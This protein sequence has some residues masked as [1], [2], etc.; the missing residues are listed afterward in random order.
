MYENQNETILSVRVKLQFQIIDWNNR[1]DGIFD[2]VLFSVN[3]VLQRRNIYPVTEK[4]RNS[5]WTV[6]QQNGLE[7]PQVRRDQLTSEGNL[8]FQLWDRGM[9]AGCTSTLGE[10]HSLC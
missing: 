1:Q 7:H 6:K 10:P 3:G 9:Q 8:T 2:S 4:N 5:A